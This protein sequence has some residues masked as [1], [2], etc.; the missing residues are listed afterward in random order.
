MKNFFFF[1]FFF[2]IN[3]FQ[4]HSFQT[5]SNLTFP[6][7]SFYQRLKTTIR[8]QL[9]NSYQKIISN[10][11]T[12]NPSYGYNAILGYDP[13]KKLIKSKQKPIATT[14][15]AALIDFYMKEHYDEETIGKIYQNINTI[16]PYTMLLESPMSFLKAESETSKSEPEISDIITEEK[17]ITN[18]KEFP[19][20][21]FLQKKPIRSPTNEYINEN[22]LK[23]TKRDNNIFVVKNSK[24]DKNTLVQIEKI[25]IFIP[26]PIFGSYNIPVLHHY[27]Y[28]QKIKEIVPVPIEI[29]VEHHTMNPIPVIVQKNQTVFI[30]QGVP[31]GVKIPYIE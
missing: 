26:I 7:S 12:L 17:I 1:S 22:V 29:A 25:P 19:N 31:F 14:P 6:N 4:I 18:P 3:L 20:F 15:N 16:N 23:E 30:P 24:N 9:Q 27:N 11:S 10:P 2:S 28:N 8:H 13:N 21:S 5:T